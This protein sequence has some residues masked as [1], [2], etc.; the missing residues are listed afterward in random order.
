ML[1]TKPGVGNISGIKIMGGKIGYRTDG[2]I[3]QVEAKDKSEM[4][5]VLVVR[6]HVQYPL[7]LSVCL[8]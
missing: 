7:L 3:T 4:K 2:G 6:G 8:S 1:I 5:Q